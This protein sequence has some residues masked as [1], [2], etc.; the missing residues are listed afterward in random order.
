[1][2]DLPEAVLV[3][4]W[5]LYGSRPSEEEQ[6]VIANP[7]SVGLD[8]GAL[9]ASLTAPTVMRAWATQ[10]VYG[11]VILEASAE[12]SIG[13]DLEHAGVMRRLSDSSPDLHAP[14]VFEASFPREAATAVEGAR[15][16]MD[17]L[18]QIA[19]AKAVATL[20]AGET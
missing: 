17:M 9:R 1:V 18:A 14:R 16:T 12:L 19:L 7:A 15:P 20:T 8:I 5:R 11:V 6:E 10:S 13:M 3:F 4:T 2:L